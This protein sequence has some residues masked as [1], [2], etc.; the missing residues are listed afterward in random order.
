MSDRAAVEEVAGLAGGQ[1]TARSS[2]G[3]APPICWRSWPSAG[4]MARDTSTPSTRSVCGPA[5]PTW[6][7]GRRAAGAGCR[8]AGGGTPACVGIGVRCRLH[9]PRGPCH[10]RGQ[11]R[12]EAP[13][14]EPGAASRGLFKA[15]LPGVS[16]TRTPAASTP[17]RW[18]TAARILIAHAE[19]IGR[20]NAVD[21]SLGAALLA[22]TAGRGSRTAG[23][24]TDLGRAGVQ[25]GAGRAVLRR[26]ALGSLARWR[27]R[28]PDAAGMVLVGR[29]VSGHSAT[30]RR[31]RTG[32]A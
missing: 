27:S 24:R 4:S 9:F 23:D 20:H 30:S 14:P 31:G 19:D 3:C 11:R 1:R 12:P 5:P 7:S 32:A 28:S 26:D 22:R 15:L 29:A 16:G 21:K 17:L 13:V 25:G 10:S 8:G 18:W 2:P 6:V